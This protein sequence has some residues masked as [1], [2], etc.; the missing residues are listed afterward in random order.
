MDWRFTLSQLSI[1]HLTM[2]ATD[3]SDALNFRAHELEM[4]KR[5]KKDVAEQYWDFIAEQDVEDL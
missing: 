3:I 5:N 2:L 1:E 4:Q